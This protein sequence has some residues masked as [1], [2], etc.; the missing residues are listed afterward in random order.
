MT[1]RTYCD[2]VES[3]EPLNGMIAITFV[4]DGQ[5]VPLLLTRHAAIML[6]ARA[7]KVFSKLEASGG[8]EIIPFSRK[9]RS[10]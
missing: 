9:R 10:A 8:A 4:S 6:V 5:K 3:A 2:D 7:G 1:G